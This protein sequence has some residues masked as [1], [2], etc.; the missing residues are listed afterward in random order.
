MV[1]GAQLC[2]S[3]NEGPCSEVKVTTPKPR[4]IPKEESRG[5]CEAFVERRAFNAMRVARLQP[6]TVCAQ[7]TSRPLCWCD[8]ALVAR[9]VSRNVAVL[10]YFWPLQFISN[11]ICILTTINIARISRNMINYCTY[12]QHG[13]TKRN[14]PTLGLYN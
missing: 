5:V 13:Q 3:Q 6:P 14:S 10:Y 12:L 1:V 2:C 4:R 7:R 11:S 8:C 9:R